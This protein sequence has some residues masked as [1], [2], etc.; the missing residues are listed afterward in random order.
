M[1]GDRV[2]EIFA[3]YFRDERAIT[4]AWRS[5]SRNTDATLRRSDVVLFLR[6][7][8]DQLSEADI[9]Y[10][11]TEALNRWLS[12]R[13]NRFRSRHDAGVGHSTTGRRHDDSG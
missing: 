11:A 12:S 9:E 8:R 4:A 13:P 10:C 6:R 5:I 2:K 3:A 7:R 1:T